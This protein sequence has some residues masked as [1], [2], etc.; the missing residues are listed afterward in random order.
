MKSVNRFTKTCLTLLFVGL[1][2]AGTGF[3]L[4]GWKNLKQEVTLNRK[5]ETTD[6]DQ[7]ESLD[8]QTS[9]IIAPSKDEQFHL[10]YYHYLRDKFAPVSHQLKGKQLTINENQP[11]SSINTNGLLDIVLHLSQQN[12]VEKRIPRLEVPKGTNLKELKGLVDIGDIDLVNVTIDT[13]EL[14]VNVGTVKL[15]NVNIGTLNLDVDTGEIQLENVRL[16]PQNSK[17]NSIQLNAGNITATNLTLTGIHQFSTD[18]GEIDL[19][20]NPKTAVNIETNVDLGSVSNHFQSQPNSQNRLILETN[21]GDI[22][23][24]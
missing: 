13:V 14:T 22:W 9:I 23:V 5:L 4:G 2:L 21:T 15:N 12:W 18:I 3:L 1:S 6:F 19:Q 20:L 16:A 11:S 10:S 7:V 24:R 17:E 8:I